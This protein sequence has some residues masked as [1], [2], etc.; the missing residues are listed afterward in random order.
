MVIYQVNL[1]CQKVQWALY[2]S[3]VA[4]QTGVSYT[5]LQEY[6]LCIFFHFPG[7]WYRCWMALAL[8]VFTWEAVN[9]VCLELQR[10]AGGFWGSVWSGL[11]FSSKWELV[12][13]QVLCLHV[14]ISLCAGE[15]AVPVSGASARVE[16]RN[17][18]RTCMLQ[19][20]KVCGRSMGWVLPS[21][22]KLCRWQW[23]CPMAESDPC[24]F[25]YKTHYGIVLAGGSAEH[26]PRPGGIPGSNTACNSLFLPG[27]F[28]HQWSPGPSLQTSARGDG[29]TT[30]HVS[31]GVDLGWRQLRRQA[32]ESAS[33][34]RKCFLI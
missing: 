24:S 25:C 29:I 15:V 11:F 8:A 23:K 3:L 26:P 16:S 9:C 28:W 5:L 10:G 14:H 18:C 22:F 33:R 30:W 6:M 7:F 17:W 27:A 12:T 2:G 34:V 4:H 31:P 13:E 19:S 21:F 20:C 32:N 1:R